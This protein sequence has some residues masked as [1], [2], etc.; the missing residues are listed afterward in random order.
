MNHSGQITSNYKDFLTILPKEPPN[1]F[2][3]DNSGSTLSYG[4]FVQIS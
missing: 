2:H 1:T 3:T 4:S